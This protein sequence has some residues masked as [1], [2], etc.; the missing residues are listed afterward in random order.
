MKKVILFNPWAAQYGYRI[1]N[2]ILQVAASIDG[3]FDF[4]LVDGN[5]EKDPWATI[6]SY[7]DTGEFG[8]FG[9][10]VM[11]G[12]QLKQAI[13]YTKKIIVVAR[14]YKKV[15]ALSQYTRTGVVHAQKQRVHL[16]Q[17]CQFGQSLHQSQPTTP[18]CNLG[19]LALNIARYD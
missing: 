1:P 18:W 5:R 11:P 14:R 8:Y 3:L 15:H 16:P 19:D 10:T 9:C 17:H 12:P 13:P 6:K 7:L 4:V 2:S